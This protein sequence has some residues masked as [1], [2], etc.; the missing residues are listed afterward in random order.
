M[1]AGKL[2]FAQVMEF[3]PWYTF[4]S[5]G[6]QVPRQFQRPHIQ[7]PGPVPM[8]GLRSADL[9]GEPA[10]H[11][12]LLAS[13]TRQALPPGVA[14]EGQPQCIGR[15]QRVS[16]LAHLRRVRS[17]ADPHRTPLVCPRAA[18]DRPGRN[19]L[20]ARLHDDQSVLVAVPL[21]ALSKDRSRGEASY[22]ARP[23]WRYPQLHPHLRR[24][25]ARRPTFST[26][27]SPKPV[28]ST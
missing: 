12:S 8:H 1:H 20:R 28:L 17:G 2:V 3:A 11:S 9:S 24:Q 16:R 27:S 18:R 23:A 5:S 22:A 21:G 7:L 10:R 6:D 25:A 26:C 14:R 19:R 15:C 4:P 13:P